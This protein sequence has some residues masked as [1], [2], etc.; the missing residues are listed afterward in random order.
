MSGKKRFKGDNRPFIL[1]H[2]LSFLSR[3]GIPRERVT[4][5][6]ATS[7]ESE[8]YRKALK[9]SD[10]ASVRIVVSTLGNKNNRNFIYCYFPKN[11]YVVSIDDDVERICWKFTDGITHHSLRTLPARGL[12]TLI[13]DARARLAEQGA[14]LWGVNTSQ[15]PRHMKSYGV[16]ERN[17]LV[18]GYLNGFICRPQCPELL[19][20]LA[21][22]TE[23]SEF[24]VRHYAKDGK[25]LRY[26]M[27]AGITS[28]YLNR[29]GLQGKFEAKGEKVTAEDRSAA[30]KCEERWGANE[31][32]RLFPR[33]IGPP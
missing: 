18:N 25:V 30:R 12:E 13:Y 29:G 8:N 31:L 19:R 22:A 17:G 15:N 9:G 1:A 5:F 20:V 2:T 32:H 3:Q 14:Y 24:A 11:A 16:S 21:D 23:D 6:V 26:R 10:W 7:T 27:Y 33:L 4:L 28:P